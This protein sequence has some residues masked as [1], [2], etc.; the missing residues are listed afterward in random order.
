[1]K[2]GHVLGVCG[3]LQ[4]ITVCMNIYSP[5]LYVL[6]ALIVIALVFLA[7]AVYFKWKRGIEVYIVFTAAALITALVPFC[8]VLAENETSKKAYEFSCY[9]V[10]I[11][12]NVLSLILA[13]WVLYHTD[14]I[15]EEETPFIKRVSS[16]LSPGLSRAAS[17]VQR[18]D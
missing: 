8:K 14:N 12:V 13:A 3:M 11:F 6:L 10:E 7:L 15:E 9:C 4:L 18:T 5:V 16:S 1:M 2:A 17:G